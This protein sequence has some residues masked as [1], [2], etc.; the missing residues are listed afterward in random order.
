MKTLVEKYNKANRVGCAVL[1]LGQM[2]RGD[3]QTAYLKQAIADHGDC[4]YGDGVQVGAFARFL[5]GQAYLKSGNGEEAKTLFDEIRND[6]PDSI[7]HNG[8]SLV[9]QLPRKSLK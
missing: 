4:F 6:Y 8:D 7:D 9:G 5:L 1:Y 2:S 3:E